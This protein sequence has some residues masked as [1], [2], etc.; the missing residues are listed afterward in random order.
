ML[1][2]FMP[3]PILDFVDANGVVVDPLSV[4]GVF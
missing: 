3:L 1:F 4:L 2:E